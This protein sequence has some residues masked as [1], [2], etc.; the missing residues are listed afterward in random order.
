M[1][2]FKRG[3]LLVNIA[4]I[5]VRHF[6]RARIKLVNFSKRVELSNR[7]FIGKNAD[8]YV[9]EFF[10]AHEY[11]SIAANFMSQTN[12]IIRPHC[13][14]SSNVSFIGKDHDIVNSKSAFLSGRTPPST[15]ILEGNNFIGFGATIM[16]NVKIG[17]GA[18]I[19]AHSLV[20]KD[21]P[22]YN[23]VA[24]SPA[25]FIKMRNSKSE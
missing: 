3:N 2:P 5:P 12:V 23:I 11:V 24:G 20:L 9:P 4:R 1:L 13:L 10:E 6:R 22:E 19:G 15:I 7:F 21:V 17:K 8:V 25:R 14:I 18:V 16:G